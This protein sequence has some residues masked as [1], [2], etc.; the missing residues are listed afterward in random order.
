MGGGKAMP[1][2][3]RV[4][5]WW[6]QADRW[7]VQAGVSQSLLLAVIHQE[8]GGDPDASRYEPGYERAY[9]LN[10]PDRLNLCEKLG[11]STVDAATSYG[12]MQLMFFTAYGYGAKSVSMLLDPDQ[13]VRFGAAHLAMLIKSRGSK[14]AA[15]AAYNGGGAA[16]QAYS[17]KVMTLY[18]EYRD[19]ALAK[20]APQAKVVIPETTFAG[21]AKEDGKYFALTE[22]SCKCG[23]GLCIPDGRLIVSL[24]KIRRAAGFPIAISSGTRCTWNNAKWGGVQG[25]STVPTKGRAGGPKDS[26]HT[27]G[28]AADITCAKIPAPKLRATIRSMWE[29]GELPY[30]AGI[31]AYPTFTHIDVDPRVAGR[32]RTWS[33]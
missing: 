9:V 16:A 19:A 14:E 23:C 28:T 5:R 18:E 29:A 11:M 27:H 4:A 13:N 1:T 15:L 22:F 32:L 26:N 2:S 6:P 21:R 33:G 24:D 7:G 31:G 10:S 8:S 3:D 30:L 17:Q 25:K 20:P 12:L